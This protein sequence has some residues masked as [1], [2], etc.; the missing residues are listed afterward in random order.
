MKR[1]CL[2]RIPRFLVLGNVLVVCLFVATPA[3]GQLQVAKLTASDGEPN[4]GFGSAVAIQGDYAVVGAPFK[5]SDPG[6]PEFSEVGAA[7]IFKRVGSS[8]LEQTILNPPIPANNITFG[9]P[10]LDADTLLIQAPGSDFNRGRL[11][12]YRRNGNSWNPEAN[13]VSS[14]YPDPEAFGSPAALDS[15]LLVAGAP[16]SGE[17]PNLNRAYVFRRTGAVWN[18]EALLQ[19]PDPLEE[20]CFSC[21]GV[22]ASGDWLVVGAPWDNGACPSEPI[23]LSGAAYVFRHQ[24]GIWSQET[25]LV[26]SDAAERLQFGKSVAISGTEIFAGA[27]GAVYVFALQEGVWEEQTKL[28]P[29]VPESSFGELVATEGIRLIVGAPLSDEVANDSGVAYV[30]IREGSSWTLDQKLVPNDAHAVHLFGSA[31]AVAEPYALVGTQFAEEAYIFDLS[32]DIPA[33][34]T[35]GLLILAL[36]V[37]AAATLLF[38]RMSHRT[39]V[40]RSQV[41]ALLLYSLLYSAPPAFPQSDSSVFDVPHHPKQLLV[42]FCDEASEASREAAHISA[43]GIELKRYHLVP[44]LTLVTVPEE[45]LSDA[46]SSYL[47]DPNV[48]YAEPDYLAFVGDAPDDLYF[49]SQWGLNDMTPPNA[50]IRAM[51]AWRFWTGDP[52]FTIAVI[53]T[54]VNLNHP[55]LVA[56][57]W[58]NTGETPGDGVDNDGN[59]YVDDIHGYDFVDDDA[60]PMEVICSHGTHVAG[61]IAAQANNAIGI[62]G[63]NW[64]AQIVALRSCSWSPVFQRCTCPRSLTLAALQYAVDKNIKVSNNSYGGPGRCPPYVF[65]AIQNARDQIGHLFI[66]SAGNDNS[67]NDGFLFSPCV[68]ELDNI[69]CVANI[70]NEDLRSASLNGSNYGRRSVDLGAPGTSI[71]STIGEEYYDDMTGTS[72]AAPHVTGVGA[73]IMS[74]RP[75]WDYRIVRDRILLTARPVAD[76]ECL[77]VTGGAVDAGAAV[78]DCNDNLI[79]DECDIDCEEEG[80]APEACGGSSDCNVNT[81]PDECEPVADCNSNEVQD[82]CD[83][84]A[85]TSAD[86]NADRIPDECQ[87][88]EDCNNNSH[89]DLCEL[90]IDPWRADCNCNL[91]IDSC[92]VASMD[93]NDNDEIDECEIRRDSVADCNGNWVPD[94]CDIAGGTSYD[95]QTHGVLNKPDECESGS[96]ACCNLLDG[97]CFDTFQDCCEALEDTVFKANWTCATAI[98]PTYN[99]PQPP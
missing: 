61:I 32:V 1:H 66:T 53:D 28:V 82:I 50:D 4:D 29:P 71:Y 45:E 47:D 80:C 11:H 79:A 92:E 96:A 10:V 51:D 70:T 13:L 39:Y 74:R 97:S 21:G 58:T 38:R 18:E 6:Q 78:W 57:R 43:S 15:D 12:I 23:C 64:N 69:I 26:A 68:C 67:D 7:Y 72:M 49:S 63:V 31:V 40:T 99:G 41:A 34:S 87:P 93:C 24:D 3:L 2:S 54:G 16:G 5:D 84:Y 75:D 62:A 48:H 85:E 33:A 59:G 65:T 73:L 90:G 81:L 22:G 8:W 25:K 27:K 20:H 76:L 98:C 17:I 94:L 14:N 91:V 36:F 9:R 55:D 52:N 42:R 88:D 95:C 19:P 89:R 83:I 30:F 37:L 60:D 44:G 46:L 56:N 35:W 86:C 77:T